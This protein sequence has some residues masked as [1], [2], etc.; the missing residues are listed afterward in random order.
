MAFLKRLLRALPLLLLS[1]L[2]M[3]VSALALAITDLLWKLFGRAVPGA[4][5]AA[6]EPAQPRW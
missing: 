3:A 5:V 1:P 4:A 6:R 2:L